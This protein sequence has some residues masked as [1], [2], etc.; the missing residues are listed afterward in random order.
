MSYV[1]IPDQDS[2]YQQWIENFATVAAANAV[3]L[4]LDTGDTSVMTALSN[5]FE[6][7]Y[8][9]SQ[10]SKLT[11]KS[12]VAAKDTARAN[13]QGVFQMYAKQINANAGVTNALKASLGITVAPSTSGPVVVPTE[14]TVIGYETGVNALA[15]KRNG[16]A[17]GTAFIIEVKPVDGGVWTM[18]TTCTNL[19]FDHTGQ[20]PG[21]RL[22]Y[23]VSAKRGSSQSVACAPVVVYEDV[24]PPVLMLQQAA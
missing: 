24:E 18:I 17:K 5:V 22:A 15:W 3:A 11:A 23:R 10:T 1:K 20:T 4:G 12:H 16:N 7:A 21:V 19:K 2:L 6:T 14:L 13:S 8:N 9:T